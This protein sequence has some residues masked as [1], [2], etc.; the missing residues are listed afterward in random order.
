M[1]GPPLPEQ[2]WRHGLSTFAEARAVQVALRGEYVTA[3][4]FDRERAAYYVTA[5]CEKGE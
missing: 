3:L 4:G 2:L 5:P 1:G